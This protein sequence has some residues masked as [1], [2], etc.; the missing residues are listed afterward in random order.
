[1]HGYAVLAHIQSMQ[2]TKK[3][4]QLVLDEDR[5]RQEIQARGFA[6]AKDFADAIGVH[7]NTI[8]HYLSGK[9]G[10]PSALARILAALDLAPAEVLSL[11]H[12]RRRVP[13][14]A[15]GDLLDRLMAAG[16]DLAI[17]L[18][19]SRARGTAKPFSDYDLGVFRVRPLE[20]AQYS[21]LLDI[22]SGWNDESLSMVQLVDFTRVDA[23]FLSAAADDLAFVA[24]SFSAWCELLRK[25]E[26]MPHE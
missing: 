15:L 9:A 22:V 14:L 12:R 7:R 18:F 1:M 16:P 21:R 3:D 13:G 20:F 26:V 6:S 8:G 23:A 10:L 11:S 4:S 5:L 25:A 2:S 17:V 24:G 19:G